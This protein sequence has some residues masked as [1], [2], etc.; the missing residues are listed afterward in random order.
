[1]MHPR[2]LSTLVLIEPVM[3]DEISGTP[4]PV[5]QA[6][7]RRDIWETRAKAE[8]YLRKAFQTWDPR[9]LD[10][11]VEYGLRE[12][13]TALYNSDRNQTLASG[14][15]TLKT[16]KHQEAWG[17]KQL[18][19]DP[20][21]E[22]GLRR[23]LRPDW[24]PTVALPPISNRPE[25][26]IAMKV[27]PYLRHSVLYVFGA[28][29]PLSTLEEQEKKVTRTGTGAGGSGGAAEGTVK[30][31]VI[32]GFGHLVIFERPGETARGAADWVRKWWDKWRA[33]ERFLQARESEKS[34]NGMLEVSKV[35]IDAVTAIS[36][37]H[38][39]K[40]SKI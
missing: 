19:L 10:R 31:H 26:L 16:T 28:K 33:D 35:W 11:L 4:S 39:R 20:R 30:G 17:Y 36:N 24:D 40:E 14:S 5:P 7:M 6:T 38:R 3:M 15:V 29:G 13:P 23:L 32:Q 25:P 9:A 2:L 12:T 37:T 18:N 8:S 21:G 27:S 1:M 22:P 34:D